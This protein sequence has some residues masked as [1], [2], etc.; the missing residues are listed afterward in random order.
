MNQHGQK[1]S[2]LMAS[3][4][5]KTKHQIFFSLLTQR[6]AAAFEDLNSSLAQF[7]GKLWSCKMAQK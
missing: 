4:T 2:P 1:S 7:T 5:K 3:L 6:F